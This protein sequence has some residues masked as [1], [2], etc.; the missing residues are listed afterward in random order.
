MA[1]QNGK[2]QN[3]IPYSELQKFFWNSCSCAWSTSTVYWKIN[4]V[5]ILLLDFYILKYKII[6]FFINK[7]Y[8]FPI[9]FDYIKKYKSMYH[10]SGVIFR[11]FYW[12]EPML[13]KTTSTWSRFFVVFWYK[14]FAFVISPY[15][16]LDLSNSSSYQF[17][18][19]IWLLLDLNYFLY[20]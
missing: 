4:F 9:L 14:M 6:C 2:L 18:S 3:F 7:W 1:G 8:T 20:Y 13:K 16:L 5:N 12:L 19:H 11:Q 15:Y 17:S 10:A